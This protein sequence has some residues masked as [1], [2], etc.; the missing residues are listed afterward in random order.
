MRVYFY[1]D[2]CLNQLPIFE[3]FLSVGNLKP[4]LKPIFFLL[5]LVPAPPLVYGVSQRGEAGVPLALILGNPKVPLEAA[6]GELLKVDAGVGAGVHV[7][8]EAVRGAHAMLTC[9]QGGH[10]L[11]KMDSN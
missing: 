11:N 2:T 8:E 3:H 1:S 6:A 9:A 7:G 4:K 5:N 10:F